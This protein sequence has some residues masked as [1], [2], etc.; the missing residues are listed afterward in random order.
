MSV[1]SQATESRASARAA[2][3]TEKVLI[4]KLNEATNVLDELLELGL[5]EF[6]SE[7]QLKEH[8]KQI[9]AEFANYRKLNK[10][11]FDKLKKVS[12]SKEMND[13]DAEFRYHYQLVRRRI[14]IINA[15]LKSK[16]L[17]SLSTVGSAAGKL[18]EQF[19]ED[20]VRLNINEQDQTKLTNENKNNSHSREIIDLTNSLAQ[21]PLPDDVNMEP[22]AF[23]A[24]AHID[25]Q[26]APGKDVCVLGTQAP[27]SSKEGSHTLS[28]GERTQ[29]S[30]LSGTHTGA[31]PR[32]QSSHPQDHPA[33]E[34]SGESPSSS[35]NF[36]NPFSNL[37]NS[38][39]NDTNHNSS[40]S[41]VEYLVREKISPKAAPPFDGSPHVFAGWVRRMTDKIK[42]TKMKPEQILYALQG[43]CTGPPQKFLNDMLAI[44]G[45]I[46]ENTL[47]IIWQK[48]TKEYGSSQRV[49]E[50]IRDKL[51]SIPAISGRNTGEQLKQLSVICQLIEFNIGSCEELQ[52]FNWTYGQ[53]IITAK[54]PFDINKMWHIELQRYRLINQCEHAPFNVYAAYIENI[55]DAYK[56]IGES[57]ITRDKNS[58]K[59]KNV[60]TMW[61]EDTG[62]K[63]DVSSEDEMTE[64]EP[65]GERKDET[66]KE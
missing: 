61:T 37:I 22:R 10:A 40:S 52:M 41:L 25:S 26:T 46:N 42:G 63:P 4:D 31:S 62:E 49:A 24:Q 66:E 18:L 13:V 19:L 45:E 65:G 21:M 6:E 16:N 29:V 17:S 33:V 7:E 59:N 39:Q 34:F 58:I 44:S 36:M 53:N 14:D 9:K 56:D 50:S 54:L 60:K 48:F 3:G 32:V 47:N 64:S 8:G 11:L 43:N 1:A 55:A 35:N 30:G 23:S 57:Y 20:S 5:E 2:T 12:A 51:N 28:A 15:E 38:D 27:P